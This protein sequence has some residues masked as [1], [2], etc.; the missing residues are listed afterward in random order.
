MS[1]LF[2]ATYPQRS[3]AVVL[4]GSYAY[5]SHLLAD[6]EFNREIKRVDRLWGTGEYFLTRYM[7]RGISEESARRVFARFER[8][9]ASPSA[10]IAICRMNREIDARH[11]LP[12]IRVPTLVMHRIGDGAIPIEAGR[13]LADNISG[14]K[15]VELP[16]TDHVPS[17]RWGFTGFEAAAG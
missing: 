12:V 15:Y 8:Q 13:Y 17:G 6:D 5:P 3:Q 11:V 7:P 9:S 2:A 16:E 10:V 4:Y 1:L 14:A